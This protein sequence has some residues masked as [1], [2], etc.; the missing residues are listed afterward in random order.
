MLH[1]P[2]EGRRDTAKL[3]GLVG[4]SDISRYITG[5]TRVRGLTGLGCRLHGG[6]KSY[7]SDLACELASD[8][9]VGP[10]PMAQKLPSKLESGE[11]GVYL[12]V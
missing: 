7:G 3:C 12:L 9:A 5:F 10:N 11:F 6:D 8:Y 1:S 4:N 2:P